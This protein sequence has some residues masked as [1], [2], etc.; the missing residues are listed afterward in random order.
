MPSMFEAALPTDAQSL[1]D[2]GDRQVQKTCPVTLAQ[3]KKE[4][5]AASTRAEEFI[6]FQGEQGRKGRNGIFSA[7]AD[8]H[9]RFARRPLSRRNFG[10]GLT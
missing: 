3:T 1:N 5:P 8:H 4:A 7:S 6:C 9:S 2:R 10:F